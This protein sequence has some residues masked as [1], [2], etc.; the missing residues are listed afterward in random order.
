[1]VRRS[2]VGD[3]FGL[4]INLERTAAAGRILLAQRLA[5]TQLWKDDGYRSAAAQQADLGGT[6][7]G[8]ATADLSTSERLR[9]LE[10]TAEALRQGKLSAEQAELISDAATI[11]PSA[12][13]DLLGAAESGSAKNLKDEAGRKSCC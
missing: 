13:Q 8:R 4:F 6:S 9:K 5:D 1:M 3:L 10:R 2:D 12:E 11:N 7:T